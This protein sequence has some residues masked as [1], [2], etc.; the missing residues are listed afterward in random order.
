MC[1]TKV[2]IYIYI[3]HIYIY[4]N[5]FT[6][7]KSNPA[8]PNVRV[9]DLPLGAPQICLRRELPL[10]YLQQILVAA[11]DL[12]GQP[13]AAAAPK[14]EILVGKIMGKTTGKTWEI[15]G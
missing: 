11:Q 15:I 9:L 3:I 13:G 1:H 7:K 6:R 12:H 4:H 8:D 14:H 5:I 2:H 10:E